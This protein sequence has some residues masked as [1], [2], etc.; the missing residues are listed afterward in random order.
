MK[1]IRNIELKENTNEELLPGYTP[2]FPY[3]ASCVE[4][5][6]YA[7]PY[8]P[9]HWHKPVE[10]FYIKSG[11]LEYT[12]PNGHYIFEKGAGGL[13]NSNV[14]HASRIV[15][16]DGDDVELIHIFDPSFISGETGSLMESKYILPL[17]T[18]PN[19]EIIALNPALPAHKPILSMI[20]QSFELPENEWGYE[21]RLRETLTRIWL[22]LLQLTNA[23]ATFT[24]AFVKQSND[25]K[26]KSLMIY[27]HEHFQE[28]ITI[29]HLSNACHLSR[30]T[31]F[32][33]FQEK[34][35]MSPVEYIRDYRLQ[36]ARRLLLETDHSVT[37][38][39]QFCGLGSSSYFGKVF[40]EHFGCSPVQ[41][42][43]E[44]AQL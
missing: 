5:S 29:D 42:R 21:F 9:W 10:L 3:I 2:K 25:E 23:N 41:Y 44:M 43:K 17:T 16:S 13:I 14:L 34:L 31:C 12:T 11:C 28:N 32:R 15:S 30:R 38:I 33:L 20:C 1:Q 37:A 35:H 6:K 8:V 39:A 22:E 27:I 18:A 26:I 24:K 4:L 19:L 36:R 7:K 40:R